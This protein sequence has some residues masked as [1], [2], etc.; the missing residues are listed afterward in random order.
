ML[1]KQEERSRIKA[2]QM[3]NLKGLLGIRWM[4]KG[5]VENDK[6]AKGVDERINEGVLQLFSYVERIEKDRIAK[7]MLVVVK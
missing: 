7:S 5:V 2:V 4:D 6:R 3:D 1:W